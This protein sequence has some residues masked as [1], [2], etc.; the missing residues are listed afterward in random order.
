[1]I[2]HDNVRKGPRRASFQIGTG[3]LLIDLLAHQDVFLA[4]PAL[5]NNGGKRLLVGRFHSVANSSVCLPSANAYAGATPAG[6]RLKASCV[7]RALRK[8][9]GSAGAQ[10]AQTHRADSRSKLPD[11]DPRKL[12]GLFQHV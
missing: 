5:D 9:A 8:Q 3:S 6:Q 7:R 12:A 4:C 1:M 11:P 2:W 10:V